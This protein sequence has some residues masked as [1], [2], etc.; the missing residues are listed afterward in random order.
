MRRPAIAAALLAATTLNAQQRA[1]EMDSIRKAELKADLFFLSSD[2]MR[3]R[4]TDTPENAIAAEWIAARFERLG[5]TPAGDGNSYYQQYSLITATSGDGN[6][7]TIGS[8]PGGIAFRSGEDFYPLR[9]STTSRASGD[10][11]F[12]GFGISS[13]ERGYDDYRGGVRGKIVLAID[14]EPGE[15]DPNSPFDGI[16]TSQVS[17]QLWK[18]LAAQER[19]A[20]GML[21]VSDVHNHPGTGG[22]GSGV[23]QGPVANGRGRGQAPGAG[24][25]FARTA[26][27][28]WPMQPPRIP[29]YMLATWV[30]RVKI[31]AVQVSPSLAEVLLERS[32]RTLADLAKASETTTGATPVPLGIAIDVNTE[33]NRRVVP[34]RNV[35]ALLEGSDPTL[36]DELVVVCAHY[37][38][39]GVN[40]D[41]VLNGADDDGSGTVGVLEIAEAFA[42]AAQKGV[43]PRRSVLFAAWNSEERGLFGAWAYTEQPLRPL[44]NTVAVLNMDMI[45]RNEEVPQGGGGRFRGLEVQ[46][47]ESNANAVN[48]IGTTRSAS[49]KEVIERANREVGLTLRLRYDNNASQLM[50]RSDHWPFL[51]RG[52]PGVWIHTGL[53]PDYHTPNDDPG[54]INYDKMEKIVRLVYQAAWDLATA[55]SRPRLH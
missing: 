36:R 25:D 19:G 21:F 46:T 48:V 13:P 27:N 10:V 9:F 14:H 34:D 28:Y 49:M 44:Q 17:D 47:A 1:P 35:V 29:R 42:A 12:A 52:V 16:V 43:R 55:P 26:S 8:G 32:Q 45:G 22:R 2:R 41:N 23:G 18:T 39:D 37:D 3:G 50:R 7:I 31:P 40:G 51:N 54:R 6:A 20:V 4:L 5:L 24:T 15:S 38:H 33:I 30:D 11:V 53:H